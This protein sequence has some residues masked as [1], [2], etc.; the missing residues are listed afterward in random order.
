MNSP[1]RRRFVKGGLCLFSASG[2]SSYCGAQPAQNTSLLQILSQHRWLPAPPP[3]A[4]EP[5]SSPPIAGKSQAPHG[6]PPLFWLS[7]NLELIKKY[8]L[9]PLRTARTLSYLSVAM[10]DTVLSCTEK[11]GNS[12]SH[13]A[14]A[15]HFAAGSVI[16]YL[17]PEELK[18]RWVG[19]GIVSASGYTSN[20]ESD[21]PDLWRLAQ[22]KARQA[23]DHALTDGSARINALAQPPK[24]IAL[25]WKAAPPLWSTRPAE[26][27]AATWRPWLVSPSIGE[28]CPPPLTL[29]AARYAK[30][31]QEVYHTHQ[32]LTPQQKKI[33]EEWNLELGTV[34]PPGVWLLKAIEKTTFSKLSLVEQ[35][36]ALS[37]LCAAMLDA[38]TACW[39]VKF[40]WW[41]ERPITA[42]RRLYDPDFLPHV[43]T[44]SF[45]SYTSG[46]AAIS[47]AA[48][49]VLS[50]LFPQH[51]D[52]WMS[53]AQEAANSRLYGGIHFRFDNE[54]G[55]A[56]GKKVA[57]LAVFKIKQ[58]QIQGTD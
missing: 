30:E 43:L 45:P 3:F 47:G 4:Q 21:W 51:Q 8:R 49:T 11:Y 20:I 6:P 14:I 52:E 27:G 12:L 34:T 48:A 18:G 5:G 38:F 37:L 32:N 58:Q 22:D 15:I 29:D 23:I 28:Q 39:Y 33:A 57:E 25:P 7:V 54:E 10:H 31:I 1:T 36:G 40:K 19:R 26:P 42:I 35:T 55:L 41:T 56:L 16:E 9:N 50:N 13:S 46:H 24:H 17:F 2:W 53:A 44:P